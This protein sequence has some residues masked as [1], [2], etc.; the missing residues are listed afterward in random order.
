[1]TKRKIPPEDMVLSIMKEVLQ[2]RRVITTLTELWS[3]V[4]MNL[5]KINRRFVI[6]SQ[7]VKHVVAKV[8]GIQ[9]KAKTRV[10]KKKLDF[11][12]VCDS[13]F[14]EIYGR[15]LVGKR[16]HTGYR[17]KKCGYKAGVKMSVPMK[18]T[19]VRKPQ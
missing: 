10:S 8:P 2:R 15:N 14:S 3:I 6:S 9:V 12:P 4:L 13:K 18:Y 5:K 19:F 16:I 1:M 17:C 7:R 11:C